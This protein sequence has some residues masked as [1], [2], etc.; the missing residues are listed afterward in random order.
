[1]AN[2]DKATPFTPEEVRIEIFYPCIDKEDTRIIVE[3]GILVCGNLCRIAQYAKTKNKN[4][5]F[6][7]IDNF[8]F[9]FNDEN[10]ALLTHHGGFRLKPRLE[11]Y[12][13]CITNIIDSDVVDNVRLITGESTE[14][15]RFF[16]NE[17]IDLLFI[18]TV[19]TYDCIKG[20]LLVWVDKVKIGGIISGHD[21]DMEGMSNG[22]KEIF[23]N[24]EINVVVDGTV[25][26]LKK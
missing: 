21:W 1:M 4:V 3:V 22:V 17:T 14:A 11:S 23:P 20:E 26:W 13:R 10:P 9:T 8:A 7:G 18:D 16:D 6:Y 2:L 24:H 12:E 15:Q 25:F 5:K 19:H